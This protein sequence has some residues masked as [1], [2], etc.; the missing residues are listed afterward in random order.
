VDMGM[1]RTYAVTLLV[2]SIGVMVAGRNLAG[3]D[4]SPHQF[5]HFHPNSHGGR[6]HVYAERDRPKVK[7]QHHD[8]PSRNE[9]SGKFWNSFTQSNPKVERTPDFVQSSGHSPERYVQSNQHDSDSIYGEQYQH[10]NHYGSIHQYVDYSHADRAKSSA[11]YDLSAA[12][13]I[14]MVTGA[15]K[16]VPYRVNPVPVVEEFKLDEAPPPKYPSRLVELISTKRTDAKH[17]GHRVDGKMLQDR[18]LQSAADVGHSNEQQHRVD[19]TTHGQS[20]KARGPHEKCGQYQELVLRAVELLDAKNTTCRGQY[21]ELRREVGDRALFDFCLESICIRDEV[22]GDLSGL[23]KGREGKFFN[24]FGWMNLTWTLEFDVL[25]AE[26]TE[27]TIEDYDYDYD[28]SELRTGVRRP[29]RQRAKNLKWRTEKEDY[30]RERE[31]MLKWEAE[32]AEYEYERELKRKWETERAENEYERELKRK[33]EA[34]KADYEY[35]REQM[36]KWE[37]EKAEFEQEGIEEYRLWSK[38]HKPFFNQSKQYD[39]EEWSDDGWCKPSAFCEKCTVSGS[40]CRRY[41]MR[42]LFDSDSEYYSCHQNFCGH[43]AS[44]SECRKCRHCKCTELYEFK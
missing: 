31:K 7:T 2:A 34:E 17:L 18:H 36:L 43:R 15:S 23:N 5:Q 27:E 42:M 39:K 10:S 25:E 33:W 13:N 22:L 11:G 26:E 35:E 1:L 32:K 3:E 6:G 28:Y 29:S 9:H 16:P 8:A 30:E 41:C 44:T 24:P 38:T 14:P 12:L 37:A 19:V 4:S 20:N 21:N 40:C